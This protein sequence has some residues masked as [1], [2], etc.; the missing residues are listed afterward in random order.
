LV[1]RVPPDLAARPNRNRVSVPELDFYIG[2][3]YPVRCREMHQPPEPGSGI[4]S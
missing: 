1:I 4:S 3:F 2:P